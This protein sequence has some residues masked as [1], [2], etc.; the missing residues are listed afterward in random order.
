MSSSVGGVFLFFLFYVKLSKVLKV[1]AKNGL[2]LYKV[3]RPS[4]DLKR[5]K[6]NF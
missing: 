4:V 3:D 6:L 2:Y 1:A 5:Y